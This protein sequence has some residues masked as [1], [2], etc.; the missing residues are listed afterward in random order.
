MENKTILTALLVSITLLSII[1]Y[2]YSQEMLKLDILAVSQIYVEPKGY[3]DPAT[4]EWKGSYWVILAST[5]TTENYLFYQFDKSETEKPYAKNTVNGKTLIPNAT[6]KV[7]VT[8]LKPYWQISLTKRTYKVLP[9]TYGTWINKINPFMYG[10]LTDT[11]VDPLYAEVLETTGVW[12]HHAP[13]QIVI[14]KTGDYNWKS[15]PITIDL[16]GTAATKAQTITSPKGESL[17]IKLIGQ[18]G[19]G[20]GQPPWS[21]LMIFSPNYVFEG[22]DKL[23]AIVS[24]DKDDMSYSNYWYGGGN[25]YTIKTAHGERKVERWNDDGSPA[26]YYISPL[27]P[28]EPVPVPD[29]AFPGSDKKDNWWDACHIIVPRKPK[30]IFTDDPN[31]KPYG[32]SLVRYLTED[33]KATKVNLNL[34]GCG[35]EIKDYKL[36]IYQPIG[37]VSWLYTLWI[38]TELADT[39][40]YQPVAANGKITSIK[41][42]STGKAYAEIGGRDAA[43]VTVKQTSTE[44]SRVIVE[45]SASTSLAKVTPT[46]DSAILEPN[47]EKTFTIIV[48]NL[49]ATSETEGTLT[50]KVYNDLGSQTDISTLQFKLLP[51]GAGDTILTVYTVDSKTKAKISGIFVSIAYG[52]QSDTKATVNGI[53]T[54]NLGSY[55]GPVQISTAETL[56]YKPTS[57]SVTVQSGQNTAIIELTEKI[58]P[59]P[60]WYIKYWWIIVIAAAVATSLITYAVTKK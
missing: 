30:D 47:E 12:E 27:Y 44:A 20:Y 31:A 60:P 56:K 16:V 55:Q 25:Y 53:A 41:W 36:K 59:E 15:K 8:A 19:T 1:A 24:Y 40:V 28:F 10:K 57:T 46:S 49:G 35:F 42:L 29:D 58:T 39:I 45:A 17:K 21:N 11:Y 9:K 34:W 14:E 37:S 26:H 13:F 2:A 51:V 5:S 43:L 52:T 18:L 4:H 33:V 3:E 23:R 54:F 50:I 7:T 32:K 6:I 22:S 38:S 48:E